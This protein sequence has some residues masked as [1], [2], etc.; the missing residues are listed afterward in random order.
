MQRNGQRDDNPLTL[1][2]PAR[3]RNEKAANLYLC[4]FI[5]N[6]FFGLR[7]AL[8]IAIG[9]HILGV[10]ERIA[11]QGGQFIIALAF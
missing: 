1:C 10:V 8:P 7:L 6:G 5:R 3:H 11:N 4:H 2:S 9:R